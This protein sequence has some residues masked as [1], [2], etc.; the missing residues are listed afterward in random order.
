MKKPSS[1]T[2]P[3]SGSGDGG[4]GGGTG[5]ASRITAIKKK[6][7]DTE[8]AM[9]RPNLPESV[10]TDFEQKVKALSAQIEEAKLLS[11][12]EQLQQKY[13]F[14]KHVELTKI[15]RKIGQLEK[16]RVRLLKS[17]GDR[18]TGD[19][20]TTD[21]TQV[22]AQLDHFRLLL[23]YV[24]FFPRDLKYVSLF[25]PSSARR[26]GGGGGG[27]NDNDDDD[28][29]DLSDADLEDAQRQRVTAQPAVGT[30]TSVAGT[31]ARIREAVLARVAAA[32][33]SGELR[34]A[35]FALR[36]R[37]VFAG[38]ER[39]RL[40]R[41]TGLLRAVPKEE[42]DGGAGRSKGGKRKAEDGGESGG[43]GEESK[44]VEGEEEGEDD[45]EEASRMQ[46]EAAKAKRAAAAAAKARAKEAAKEQEKPATN[47][48]D[49]D[50]FF[51][52][53]DADA[54]GNASDGDGEEEAEADETAELEELIAI[55]EEEEEG[56]GG[57]GIPWKRRKVLPGS[58]PK[59]PKG[60]PRKRG[61]VFLKKG[62]SI[63]KKLVK[64]W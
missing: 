14:I 59:A 54:D 56:E 12:E 39:R 61:G 17:E 11:A 62:V 27:K 15:L 13:R 9:R 63:A 36:L 28:D 49:G 35:G 41:M 55:N 34:E 53:G 24:E 51:L 19:G 5:A 29:G 42:R 37:D 58:A 48:V 33:A 1:S 43:D 38:A 21:V 23:A 45:E 16:K 25:P 31:T 4:G 30:A 47:G 7:R 64:K 60:R 6:L 46:K 50:D 32:R 40:E 44:E 2:L 3:E 10:R 22:D 20:A 57:S 18:K 26:D 8:R 52:S